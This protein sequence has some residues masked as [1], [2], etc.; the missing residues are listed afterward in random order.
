MH[1]DVGRLYDTWLVAEGALVSLCVEEQGGTVRMC[2]LPQ[3]PG[4]A[5]CLNC[6]G[7]K[8]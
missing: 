1:M 7:W 5:S 3:R 8:R 4:P 2:E 6:C